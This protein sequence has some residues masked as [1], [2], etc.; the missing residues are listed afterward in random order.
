MTYRKWGC[1][2][3]AW[4]V[5]LFAENPNLSTLTRT[6]FGGQSTGLEETVMMGALGS[7]PDDGRGEERVIFVST[8]AILV[9]WLLNTGAVGIHLRKFR[10]QS[11]TQG[12]LK[13]RAYKK[14]AESP[15]QREFR[16]PE[17]TYLNRG[18]NLWTWTLNNE[19]SLH[20]IWVAI[21]LL[22]EI[23]GHWFLYLLGVAASNSRSSVTPPTGFAGIAKQSLQEEA[24]CPSI[25]TTGLSMLSRLNHGILGG[26]II[27]QYRSTATWTN[28]QVWLSYGE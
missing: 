15:Y 28:I 11:H 13:E 26:F 19:S 3:R 25:H 9:V 4:Y 20:L 18:C 8:D 1:S 21:P 24:L 17:W 12:C 7:W 10:P 14:D 27:G 16:Y 22:S 2:P 23:S 5:M 6:W